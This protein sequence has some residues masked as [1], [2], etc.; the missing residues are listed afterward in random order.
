MKRILV[1]LIS[2]FT[3]TSVFGQVDYQVGGAVNKTNNSVPVVYQ[4][5]NSG[6]AGS[7]IILVSDGDTI[8]LVSKSGYLGIGTS[9]PT[10]TLDVEGSSML[11]DP[12]DSTRVGK[13]EFAGPPF[14]YD[15]RGFTRLIPSGSYFTTGTIEAPL[16]FGTSYTSGLFNPA[17]F[18]IEGLQVLE[19]SRIDIGYSIQGVKKAAIRFNT[20]STIKIYTNDIERLGI[21]KDGVVTISPSLKYTDGNESDGY[22]LTSDA[23]GNATWQ[24]APETTL[25]SD[26]T[27]AITTTTDWET[28]ASYE[29]PANTLSSNGNSLEIHLAHVGSVLGDSLRLVLGSSEVFSISNSGQNNDNLQSTIVRQSAGNQLFFYASDFAT[30][31]EDETTALTLS[32]QAKSVTIGNQTLKY[33][34][35]KRVE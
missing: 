18:G 17:S 25:Y 7:G 11:Y 14:A 6:T 5:K 33:F 10:K 31:T 8:E 28:L 26:V 4:V 32:F 3:I 27:E 35:V 1:T 21:D 2:L 34:K 22:V 29:I 23:S 19:D 30:A 13:I 15:I 9:T 16:V 12:T 24:T 20:D